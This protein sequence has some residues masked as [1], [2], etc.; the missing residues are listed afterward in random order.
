MS[1]IAIISDIHG[2]YIALE[3]I[4]KDIEKKGATEIYCLGDIVPKFSQP[5]LVLDAIKSN[6]IISVKGNGEENVTNN[7]NYTYTWDRIG[8]DGIEYLKSLP[9]SHDLL[10]SGKLVRLLHASP[11]SFVHTYNPITNNKG[12][13]YEQYSITDP[14][15]LFENTEFIGKVHTDRVPDVVAY[16]HVHY[17][18][19]YDL[20]GK[21][22]INPGSVGEPI[23]IIKENDDKFDKYYSDEVTY[24][25]I[26]GVLNSNKLDD[27]NVEIVK[28]PYLELLKQVRTKVYLSGMPT[29]DTML[30]KID[31][32][33]ERNKKAGR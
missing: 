29:T 28:L 4:L 26:D 27:F 10:I 12:S 30:N 18:G 11:I 33:L 3:A 20:D 23:K 1:K 24:L 31:E 15:L 17:P 5:E 9:A 32:G 2:N 13:F 19:I 8:I 16:G 6:G 7:P 14:R 21:M 22:I 25:L